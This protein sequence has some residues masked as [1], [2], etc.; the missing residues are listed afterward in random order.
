M[1]NAYISGI[2]YYM[3]PKLLTNADLEKMVD[4]TDEWI[5][6][7][8]GIKSRHI[9]DEDKFGSDMGIEAAKKAMENA[10]VS[11]DEIDMLICANVT[12]DYDTPS[13]SCIIQQ[14]V[15]IS[16][17]AAMDLNAAC[18]G[19]VYALSVA[20]AYITT[21]EYKNILIVASEAMSK[22]VDWADRKSC[23]L[24]GDGA[25]A[26]VVSATDEDCGVLAMDIG[27]DG[28]KGMLLTIPHAKCTKE[29]IEKRM[30]KDNPH[31][32]WMNGSEVFKFAVRTMVSSTMR[33][34]EKA[35][36]TKEDI[37]LLIPH[38]ANARIIDAS[39]KRLAMEDGKVINYI[40]DMGNMS[41]AC[42]PIALARAVE[43]RKIKDGD[44]IVIVGFGGGL[45]WASAYIKWKSGK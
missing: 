43:D 16:G 27:A 17:A 14:A 12:Q 26:A 5:V 44:E 32:F 39:A 37:D 20:R 30:T 22:F 7:H 29:D 35:G 31:V 4:T 23:V 19:F 25:G 6:E 24:F 45:T 3:P 15:G 11:A 10:G 9:L 1:A 21:G 2:G 8:S 34:I 40:S 38:Q 33:V 28:R 42:I 13:N 41:A 18:T 36:K